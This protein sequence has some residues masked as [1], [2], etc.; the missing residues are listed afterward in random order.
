MTHRYWI[1]GGQ[2]RDTDFSDLAPESRTLNGPFGSYNDALSQWRTLAEASR[3]DAYTRF[4]IAVEQ[5]R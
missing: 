3:H 5:G 2:Y 4:T 1:V